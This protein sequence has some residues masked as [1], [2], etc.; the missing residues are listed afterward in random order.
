MLLLCRV[1]AMSCL[2]T[3]PMTLATTPMTPVVVAMCDS[4][5]MFSEGLEGVLTS[6]CRLSVDSSST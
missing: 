1:T 3:T 5:A 4:D 2:A 6:T